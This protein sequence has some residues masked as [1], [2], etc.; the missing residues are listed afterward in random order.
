MVTPASFVVAII[1]V[2]F[3]SISHPVS[4]PAS[5][6]IALIQGSHMRSP[7]DLN[8]ETFPGQL[9]IQFAVDEIMRDDIDELAGDFRGRNGSAQYPWQ[10]ACCHTTGTFW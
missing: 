6:G 5:Y 8:D 7:R 9:G 10:R 4:R 2:L 3:G 1:A